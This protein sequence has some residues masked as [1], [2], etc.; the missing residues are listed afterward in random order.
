MEGVGVS[1]GVTMAEGINMGGE[2]SG[3]MGSRTEVGRSS[4]GTEV[5]A[6]NGGDGS[7]V[8]VTD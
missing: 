6:I 1:S 4:G 2:E 5:E 3:K 8:E 7:E